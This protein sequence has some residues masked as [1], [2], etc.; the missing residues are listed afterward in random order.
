MKLKLPAVSQP[1]IRVLVLTADSL[2]RMDLCGERPQEVD[3]VMPGVDVEKAKV[4]YVELSAS[5]E[6]VGEPVLLYEPPAPTPAPKAKG[7]VGPAGYCAGPAESQGSNGATAPAAS[8]DDLS[9]EGKA[10]VIVAGTADELPP[11]TVKVEE[12]VEVK[13]TRKK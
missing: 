9:D 2:H 1:L 8:F 3:V 13:T 6:E 5:G 12:K 10:K 7:P 4:G 11:E